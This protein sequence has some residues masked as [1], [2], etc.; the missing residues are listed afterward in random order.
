MTDR[1]TIYRP[2][3]VKR[4]NEKQYF[5][6]AYNSTFCTESKDGQMHMAP[7]I[8]WAVFCLLLGDRNTI[9]TQEIIHL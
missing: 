1:M 6:N 5:N 4:L 7:F 9:P 2:A 8:D 3:A